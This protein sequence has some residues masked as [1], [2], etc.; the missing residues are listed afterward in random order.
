MPFGG[1]FRG[2]HSYYPLPITHYP[3]PTQANGLHYMGDS[4]VFVIFK[5]IAQLGRRRSKRGVD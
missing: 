5:R 4:L 3:L 1:S 2:F